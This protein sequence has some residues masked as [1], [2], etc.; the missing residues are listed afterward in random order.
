MPEPHVVRIPQ[1]EAGHARLGHTQSRDDLAR[2][3]D[4]DALAAADACFAVFHRVRPVRLNDE[5]AGAAGCPLCSFH[6]RLRVSSR[7]YRRRGASRAAR[8][9]VPSCRRAV[10]AKS[11]QSLRPPATGRLN[12]FARAECAPGAAFQ[13]QR[14]WLRPAL[15]EVVDQDLAVEDAPVVTGGRRAHRSSDRMRAAAG[16]HRAPPDLNQFG[17]GLS[18]NLTMKARAREFRED[19]QPRLRGRRDT[20]RVTASATHAESTFRPSG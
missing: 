4:D 20:E 19:A 14:K 1:P 6:V 16:L 3:I 11:L 12:T 8:R 10:D 7:T 9:S 13:A 18:A 2:R 15:S 5:G 17:S